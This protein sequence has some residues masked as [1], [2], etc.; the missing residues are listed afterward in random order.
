MKASGVLEVTV[1]NLRKEP[2][3][4]F[5][6]PENGKMTFLRK[7]PPGEAADVETALR[8]IAAPLHT[9]RGFGYCQGDPHAG[10]PYPHLR[11]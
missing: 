2:A 11:P 3:L 6:M 1:V 7:L 9:S 10:L 4:L 5:R 8:H